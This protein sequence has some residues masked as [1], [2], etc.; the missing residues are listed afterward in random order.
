MSFRSKKETSKTGIRREQRSTNPRERTPKQW[1]NDKKP[2]SWVW[3]APKET[4]K[5][6]WSTVCEWTKEKVCWIGQ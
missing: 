5:D 6:E 4:W 3:V 1:Q 2:L